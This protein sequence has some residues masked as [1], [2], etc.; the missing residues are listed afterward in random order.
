LKKKRSLSKDF[1]AD[2]QWKAYDQ[3]TKKM[4]SKRSNSSEVKTTKAKKKPSSAINNRRKALN[5]LQMSYGG[6]GVHPSANSNAGNAC[7]SPTL[8]KSVSFS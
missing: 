4:N 1:T 8:S 3:V 2:A 5:Q 7:D 6:A